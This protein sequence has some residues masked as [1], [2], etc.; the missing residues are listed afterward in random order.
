MSITC[1]MFFMWYVEHL[2]VPSLNRA[3]YWN[4]KKKDTE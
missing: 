3:Y 1:E 4:D 2:I